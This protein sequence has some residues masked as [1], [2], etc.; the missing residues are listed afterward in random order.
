MIA[1]IT[2]DAPHR[3]TQDLIYQ[4]L[5]HGHSEIRLIVIPWVK[6][7]NFQ[8]IYIHR[9]SKK[10][11]LKVELLCERLKIEYAKLSI[12]ELSDYFDQNSFKHI[13]I[14]G[15][16]I[17][18]DDL[19]TNHKIINGHPGYLPNMKGLDALKWGIFQGQPIGVTTHYI[20]DKT[21]EGKLIDQRIVPIFY[22]DTF[23]NVAYRVYETEI[24]MLA[25]SI[26]QIDSNKASLQSLEDDRYSPNRRMPHHIEIIMMNRF[27]ELRKASK[28]IKKI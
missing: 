10:V 17:L 20:S 11:D 25:N 12:P 7:K 19:V 8:P 28:S 18:P 21:D 5:L 22:E 14:G 16:G 2:Y 13:L 9:P 23:H 4:L 26:N 3:K 6:R 27:E 1:I 15:A 24:E